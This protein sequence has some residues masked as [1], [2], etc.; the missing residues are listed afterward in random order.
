MEAIMTKYT[1]NRDVHTN[2]CTSIDCDTSTSATEI[3]RHLQERGIACSAQGTTVV[4]K[5]QTPFMEVLR[6][7]EP[8]VGIRL[9]SENT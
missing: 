6:A 5:E 1:W 8:F 4:F 7:S 2:A 3:Q 9:I